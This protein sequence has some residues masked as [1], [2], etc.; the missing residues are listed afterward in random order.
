MQERT[1]AEQSFNLRSNH[2]NK[3][4]SFGADQDSD[5]AD[6]RDAENQ[7]TI[8]RCPIIHDADRSLKSQRPAYH[9]GLTGTQVPSN[10]SGIVR[11]DFHDMVPT[12]RGQPSTGRVVRRTG[13]DLLRD[14]TWQTELRRQIWQQR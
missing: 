3:A 8:P 9:G 5:T 11:D 4:G 1:S 6:Y 7:S 2:R 13:G 12:L 10:Y 14:F